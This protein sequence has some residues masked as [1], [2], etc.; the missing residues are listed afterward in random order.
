MKKRMCL[1]LLTALLIYSFS[2]NVFACNEEQTKDY[3]IQILFGDDA[4]RYEDNKNIELILSA[5]YICSEQSDKEGQEKLNLLEKAKVG[6]IPELNSINVDSNNLLYCSHN[7]WGYTNKELAKIQDARK[8]VLRKTVCKV[9]DFGWINETFKKEEGKIDSFSALLYYSHILADYIAA[10]PEDTELSAKGYDIPAY[11]GVQEYILNG[12][13]PSF[14]D[15]Q[16]K[17]LD[18]YYEYG[19]H[20]GYGRCGRAIANISKEK[21]DSVGKRDNNAV[22]KVSPT[23]WIEGNV[24]HEILSST[25]YNRCHLIAHMLGGDDTQWNLVTGT[26]YLNSAMEYYENKI[27][28]HINE[29]NCHVLYRVTPVYKGDNLVAS[30]VQLEAYSIEDN[31]KLSFNVYLYNVQPGIDIDYANGNSEQTDQIYGNDGSI[32]FVILNSGENNPD[33]LFEISEQLNKLFV[34][35]TYDSSYKS[36]INELSIIADEARNVSGEKETTM[37]TKIKKYQ[38]EYMET[39]IDYVPELLKNEDF[40]KVE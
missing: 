13:V 26:S 6:N 36:M 22:H 32:P 21:I 23:G 29:T 1:C 8:G 38:Y 19:D 18:S 7:A 2:Y 20:D 30:G 14:T 4:F 11:S 31:G 16:K 33:L 3:I 28:N 12:N 5:L 34:D 24:N 35:Q 10:E 37:Y 9:F 25:L 15:E 17:E 27:K 39:L 40:F